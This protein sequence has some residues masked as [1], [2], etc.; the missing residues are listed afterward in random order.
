MS[1]QERI[2]KIIE[3]FAIDASCA[4]SFFNPTTKPLSVE[5]QRI[6]C[7]ILR[8]DLAKRIKVPL[9]NIVIRILEENNEYILEIDGE[10]DLQET[11]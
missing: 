10:A 3:D 1:E 9:D 4:V 5:D 11:L 7:L 8:A 2:Q 6:G